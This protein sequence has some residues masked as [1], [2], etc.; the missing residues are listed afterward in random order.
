MTATGSHPA[1]RSGLV[2]IKWPNDLVAADGRKVAG[3]LAEG[4]LSGG[5]SGSPAPVVVGI[6]INANWPVGDDDGPPELEGRAVSLA[7]LSGGPVDRDALM[8]ALLDALPARVDALTTAEGRAGLAA[9]LAPSDLCVT[10]GAP[11]RVELAGGVASRG[12]PP[13][14][15]VRATWSSVARRGTVQW[16]PATWSTCRPSP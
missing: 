10:V 14:S 15:P 13:G 11:V 16:W 3:V 8:G 9:D 2:G 1:R 4:D 5:P 7:R 12:W 6:G